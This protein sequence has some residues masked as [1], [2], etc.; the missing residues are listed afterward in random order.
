[1][2]RIKN[3]QARLRLLKSDD[4]D[5]CSSYSRIAGAPLGSPVR[6]C[7]MSLTAEGERPTS[8]PI[9]DR[10]IP[11]RRRS[12]E[13]KDA[14][15]Y[16][17]MRPSLRCTVDDSQR[18]PVTAL[19]DNPGMPRPPE[20]PKDLDT[21]GKRVRWWRE[22]KRQMSRAKLAKAVGYKSVSGLSDLELGESNASEKLHLI[23]AVLGLNPHYLETG[24]G[25][26][27]AAFPQD[28][29]PS[30][31]EWPFP[32]VPRARLR[33]LSKIERNYAE[34]KLLEALAEIESER[35]NRTG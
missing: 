20:M 35:R 19:R 22:K 15:G 30:P 9:S 10:V 17:C 23:A 26:P 27:E 1:M 8:S 18:L 7:S 24:N 25:E 31:D 13:M 29:P 14:K 34:T 5:L 4:F 16:V 33:K 11:A 32:A 2:D 12:S 3:D 6:P 21:I 28:P